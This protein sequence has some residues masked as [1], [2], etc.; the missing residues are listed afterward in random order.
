MV[1]TIMLGLGSRTSSPNTIDAE[2][3]VDGLLTISGT[4]V[5]FDF[6]GVVSRDF[7]LIAAETWASHKPFASDGSQAKNE[8]PF[9]AR[10][11][12]EIC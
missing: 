7:A 9:V 3:T 2:K 12:L 8:T 6:R 5:E 10:G 11:L 4:W 1:A